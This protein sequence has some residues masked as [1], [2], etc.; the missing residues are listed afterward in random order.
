MV[1]IIV[2]YHTIIIGHNYHFFLY[3]S[4]NKMMKQF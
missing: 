3:I 2:H 1:I 4:F